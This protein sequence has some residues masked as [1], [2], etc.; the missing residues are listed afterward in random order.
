MRICDLDL[1]RIKTESC[2]ILKKYKPRQAVASDGRYNAVLLLQF[3]FEGML[4][5]ATLPLCLVIV[6]S[7][8]SF[9]WSPGKLV[10]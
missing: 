5:I 6:C 7:H 3:L 2:A 10:S 8:L 4:V 9:Y 1:R